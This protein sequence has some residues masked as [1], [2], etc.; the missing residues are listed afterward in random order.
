MS[1]F[2]TIK[3]SD[4]GKSLGTR[5]FGKELREQVVS[6]IKGGNRVL[7]DF[8]N[9]NIISSAFADELFGKLFVELG[10][11]VF[12]DNIKVNKFDNEEAK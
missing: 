5:E 1:D 6:F 10:E 3:L 2:K 7:F 8:S 4:F 12:K 9:I 11:S